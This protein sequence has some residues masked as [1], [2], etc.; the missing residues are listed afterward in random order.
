M[1]SLSILIFLFFAFPKII[2]L[3]VAEVIFFCKQY[4]PEI[5]ERQRLRAAKKA[6]KAEE[7]ERRLRSKAMARED[8]RRINNG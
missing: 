4:L 2:G 1:V 5:E 8:A 6:A 7:K 3:Q